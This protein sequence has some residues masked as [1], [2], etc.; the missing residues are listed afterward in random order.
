MKEP[1]T[2][3]SRVQPRRSLPSAASLCASGVQRAFA[4]THSRARS[5]QDGADLHADRARAY[6]VSF[7]RVRNAHGNS[8]DHGVRKGEQFVWY[9][10]PE[11]LGGYEIDDQIE[12]SWLLDWHVS[13]VC[14]AQY[15][16]D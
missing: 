16:V 2:H 5:H 11:R 14:S 8:F 13:G 4:Q 1:S 15:L 12:F 10:K 6:P 3:V 9:R 7:I